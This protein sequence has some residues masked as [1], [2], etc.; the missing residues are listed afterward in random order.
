MA[1]DVQDI[2]TTLKNQNI[3][4]AKFFM[5]KTKKNQTKS[6]KSNNQ[7]VFNIFKLREISMGI[8][9]PTNIFISTRDLTFS[10]ITKTRKTINY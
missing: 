1:N 8:L 5:D 10:K 3:D 9:I 4:F 2:L 7:P 6:L